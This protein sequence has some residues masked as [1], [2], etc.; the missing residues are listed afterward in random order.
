MFL[1]EAPFPLREAEFDHACF[2]RRPTFSFFLDETY[3]CPVEFVDGE[4]DRSRFAD[5]KAKV[6][7]KAFTDVFTTPD[8][9][10]SR[11]AS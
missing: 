10:A 3:P 9:L 11:V 5:F 2:L 4:P 7:K 1:R 8:V 6:Q